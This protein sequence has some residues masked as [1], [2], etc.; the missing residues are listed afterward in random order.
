MLRV[1]GRVSVDV[2]CWKFGTF[3]AAADGVDGVIKVR[4]C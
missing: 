3:D 4:R 2:S 1:G